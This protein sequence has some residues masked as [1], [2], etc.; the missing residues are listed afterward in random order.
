MRG[1]APL[2]GNQPTREPIGSVVGCAPAEPGPVV[3]DAGRGKESNWAGMRSVAGAL[4][5]SE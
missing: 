4:T 2:V 1:M 3:G 5:G